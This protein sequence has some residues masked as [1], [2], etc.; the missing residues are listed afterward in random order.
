MRVVI[1]LIWLVLSCHA[2][3]AELPL[4]FQSEQEK[5]RFYLLIHEIRCVVCQGQS[6]AE[7][8]APLANDLRRKVFEQLRQGKSEHDIKQYLIA[9]YGDSILFSPPFSMRTVVLWLF[10]F[11]LLISA[12]LFFIFRYVTFVKVGIYKENK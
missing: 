2:L 7:S 1:T 12:M 4:S 6:I 10:P 3:S 9:R 5:A 8:Q 11:V